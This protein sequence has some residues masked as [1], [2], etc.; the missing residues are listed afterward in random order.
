MSNDLRFKV[1]R[2]AHQNPALRPHLLPL[3]GSSQREASDDLIQVGDLVELRTSRGGIIEA[4]V[5]EARGMRTGNVDVRMTT[6][7]GKDYKFRAKGPY[8]R[9]NARVM[10]LIRRQSGKAVE[11]ARLEN[12]ERRDE[13]RENKEDFAELGRKALDTFDPKPGD[14]VTIEYAVNGVNWKTGK[15]GIM[16][17]VRMTPEEKA[18]M[19]LAFWQLNQMTGQNVRP[20]S[21]RD[22]RWIPAQQI[23]RI[24]RLKKP[25]GAP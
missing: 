15:V 1:I 18:R 3:L 22:T 4:T 8:Y 23:V 19:E 25:A 16:K 24:E 7:D 9:D 14:L 5:V 11:Q 6:A 2:L 10:K 21:E 20:P 12:R 13:R 17:P